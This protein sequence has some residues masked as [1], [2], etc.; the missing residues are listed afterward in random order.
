MSLQR[1]P[2]ERLPPP[3]PRRLEALLRQALARPLGFGS[4]ILSW[5]VATLARVADLGWEV[6]L[7]KRNGF[8]QRALAE[9]P[10]AEDP[11]V[12]AGLAIAA[13]FAAARA[14]GAREAGLVEEWVADYR[15]LALV[16]AHAP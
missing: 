9:Q 7:G 6:E 16:Y 5:Q 4:A 11:A 12:A 15:L 1:H 10:G 14:S 3:G 13:L 2:L 8:V